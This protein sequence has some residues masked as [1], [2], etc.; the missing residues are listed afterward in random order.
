[1]VG[2]YRLDN[3]AHEIVEG[4]LDERG[5]LDVVVGQRIEADVDA[6]VCS[7]DEACMAP[8]RGAVE[9]VRPV[10]WTVAPSRANALA[11]AEPIAPAAP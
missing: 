8:D 1:M 10:R 4:H 7:R 11:T 9:S 2:C 5:A 6:A 3:G